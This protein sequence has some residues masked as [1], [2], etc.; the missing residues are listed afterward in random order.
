MKPDWK[1]A[2]EWANYLAM[3]SNGE[4]FWYECPPESGSKTWIV[5]GG[6]YTYAEQDYSWTE[7]KEAR[8]AFLQVSRNEKPC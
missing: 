3:D 8:P 1:D 7:T 6:D 2:P 5:S 4:W